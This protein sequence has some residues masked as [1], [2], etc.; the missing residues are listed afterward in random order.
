MKPPGFIMCFLRCYL[1]DNVNSQHWNWNCSSFLSLPVLH[2][3]LTLSFLSTHN[4]FLINFI[5]TQYNVIIYIA[6]CPVLL[7]GKHYKAGFF[8][9]TLC[10]FVS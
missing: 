4:T 2:T 6:L 1:I 3:S 10:N 8:I 5:Y 9:V 7:K